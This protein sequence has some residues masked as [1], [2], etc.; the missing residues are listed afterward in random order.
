MLKL[1]SSTIS[2]AKAYC[3]LE[4]F[5]SVWHQ[6]ISAVYSDFSSNMWPFFLWYYI[7]FCKICFRMFVG[8]MDIWINLILTI[9]SYLTRFLWRIF[10]IRHPV[11]RFILPQVSYI[12]HLLKLG[13]L[14]FHAFMLWCWCSLIWSRL[15][16]KL[17]VTLRYDNVVCLSPFVP[18]GMILS[19]I[20]MFPYVICLW[21]P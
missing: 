1:I 18:L 19:L 2:L 12:M 5:L 15:I 11:S 8:V 17:Y 20:L 3:C 21:L 6:L 13:W 10:W 14:I 4:F 9:A 7:Q 16:S